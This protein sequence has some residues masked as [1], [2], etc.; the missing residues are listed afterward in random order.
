MAKW[1]LQALLLPLQLWKVAEHKPKGTGETALPPP[2]PKC[3]KRLPVIMFN[4]STIYRLPYYTRQP[5]I[6]LSPLSR[7]WHLIATWGHGPHYQAPSSSLTPQIPHHSSTA[8]QK[9][10]EKVTEPAYLMGKKLLQ[11]IST[12]SS[13]LQFLTSFISSLSLHQGLS[14]SKEVGQKDLESKDKYMNSS[15]YFLR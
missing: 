11:S 9:E 2:P 1:Y 10:T 14:L 5:L 7:Q 6:P 8:N 4:G 13:C 12:Q 3:L 15:Y